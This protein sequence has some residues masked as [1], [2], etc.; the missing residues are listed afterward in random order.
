MYIHMYIH[1][2]HSNG[3]NECRRAAIQFNGHR[4]YEH[5]YIYTHAYICTTALASVSLD[6]QLYNSMTTACDALWSGVFRAK[7]QRVA[8][9]CSVLQRVAVCC[10]VL[11]RVAVCCSVLQCVAVYCSVLQRVAACCSVLQRV[12]VYCSV[13]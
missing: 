13:L 10:S 7:M 4:M 8:V 2:H 6:T 12:A 9:C 1:R 3:L 5:T 11:L